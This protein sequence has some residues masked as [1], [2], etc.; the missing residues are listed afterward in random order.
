[1]DGFALI[2]KITGN[3]DQFLQNG[4]SNEEINK[5]ML[6]RTIQKQIGCLPDKE[7]KHLVS[8]KSLK[9]FPVTVNDIANANSIPGLHTHSSLKGAA[10]RHTLNNRVRVGD[11]VKIPRDWYKLNK[12][13]TL[14]V[15]A[16]FVNGLPLFVTL[17]GKINLVTAECVSNK[18]ARQL[19]S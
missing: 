4:G 14:T 5:A 13:T 11:S 1:M 2:E 6:S 12:F 16:M 7:F 18:K 10:T 8:T 15:D 17:L 3:I 19:L 9:Q